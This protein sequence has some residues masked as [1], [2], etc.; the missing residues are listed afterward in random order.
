[1]NQLSRKLI[2]GATIISAFIVLTGFTSNVSPGKE[3][4]KKATAKKT[5]SFPPSPYRIVID[6]SDFELQV[7]DGDGWQATY[8]V[9]FGNKKQEDH[10]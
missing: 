2:S 10:E 5:T 3:K 6:K 7:F 9:V 8:P 4:K 1:M